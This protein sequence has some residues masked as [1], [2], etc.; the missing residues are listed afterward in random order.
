MAP[1]TTAPLRAATGRDETLAALP[2]PVKQSPLPRKTEAAMAEREQ[3]DDVMREALDLAKP[4]RT[5]WILFVLALVAGAGLSIFLLTRLDKVRTDGAAAL[6]DAT[7]KLAEARTSRGEIAQ[8]L[9]TMEAEK[10]DLLSL[11]NELSEQVKVKEDELAK[12]QGTY[13]E[14]EQKMKEEIAKGDVRL[15]QSGGRIKVDLVDKILFD[16]GEAT[17]TKRGGDVLSRVGAVLANV[18]DK[19]IQVSGHTDDSPIVDKALKEK[20]PTN[21]ELAS[22][23]ATVVVRYLEE[24]AKVPGRLLVAAAYGPWEPISTNANPSGRA[25]NR[26][27][28]IVLTPALAPVPSEPGKAP[29]KKK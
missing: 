14:L 19:K 15:S 4:S 18:K 3:Y 16:V 1:S 11:K 28:E 6:A 8:R 5:P 25:R 7:T 27:I 24:K 20:F 23:R 21:W 12:L 10:A 13:S 26:R 17:I 29:A 2:P 22:A 9:E